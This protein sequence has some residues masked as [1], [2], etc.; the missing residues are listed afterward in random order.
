M[1]LTCGWSWKFC[2]TIVGKVTEF[3]EDSGNDLIIL[4]SG[5]NNDHQHDEFIHKVIIVSSDCSRNSSVH[6]RR[7]SCPR[8]LQMLKWLVQ[9]FLQAVQEES[10]LQQRCQ[11]SDRVQ[12]SDHDAH[13][14]PLLSSLTGQWSGGI[15]A[16]NNFTKVYK[17][18]KSWIRD[19]PRNFIL[20][21]KLMIS[22]SKQGVEQR[23]TNLLPCS[24]S[25]CN[26]IDVKRLPA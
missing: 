13:H 10:S 23:K 4:F 26:S 21:L 24:S 14:G 11:L 8:L 12:P 25:G 15:A 2:V 19:P 3:T 20:K 22:S 6:L 18:M 7:T 17:N 5:L 16:N 9:I 1:N